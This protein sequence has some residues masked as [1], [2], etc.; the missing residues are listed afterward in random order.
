MADKNGYL[1]I[2]TR[3]GL[4]RFDP[5]SEIFERYIPDSTVVQGPNNFGHICQN[6]KGEIFF[7]QSGQLRKII[8]WDRRKFANQLS[9]SILFEH[10]LIDKKDNIWL[11]SL[12][13][14]LQLTPN[15]QENTYNIPQGALNFSNTFFTDQKQQ[16]WLGNKEGLSKYDPIL[17][18]FVLQKQL[19]RPHTQNSSQHAV[20]QIIED[21][22]GTYWVGTR[23]GL[24]RLIPSLDGSYW[25][26]LFYEHNAN[27][28]ESLADNNIICIYEDNAGLIWIGTSTAFHFFDPLQDQ[29][30]RINSQSKNS[31]TLTDN[32]TLGLCE[33]NQGQ[34][35]VGLYDGGLDKISF[36]GQFPQ[37]STEQNWST[38]IQMQSNF[39]I[40]SPSP[41][42]LISNRILQVKSDK[43]NQIWIGTKIGLQLYDQEKD[44]VLLFPRPDKEQPH[45]IYALHIDKQQDSILWIGGPNGL[46]AFDTYHQEYIPNQQF[47]ADLLAMD[48]DQAG[49]FWIGSVEGIYCINKKGQTLASFQH[50]P[51]DSTS[52]SHNVI[53]DIHIDKTQNIW[54]G[55]LG[56]GL[57][58]LEPKSKKITRYTTAKGLSSDIIFGIL[59]DEHGYI[60]ASTNDGISKL[61]TKNDKISCFYKSE[62][63]NYAD[64]TQLSFLKSSQGEFLFGT[65]KGLNVFHPDSLRHNSFVPPVYLTAV[66]INYK[67]ASPQVSEILGTSAPFLQ[68]LTL[69]P[70]EKH[71]SFEFA[72]LNF[73]NAS[74][75]QYKFRLKGYDEKWVY[76][77]GKERYATYTNLPSGNYTFQ[78]RASN[79]NNIW[80]EE[81]LDIA[82]EVLPPF[83]KTWWFSGL[84]ILLGIGAIGS[85]IYWY[86]RRKYLQQIQALELQQ[87]VQAERERISR[88][89]H[90]NVGAQ[91]TNIA[92]NLDIVGYQIPKKDNEYIQNRIDKVS[93]N[94]RHTIQLLRDTIWAINKNSFTLEE[95]A[96]KVR[97]YLQKYLEDCSLKWEVN[98]VGDSNHRLSPTQVL[99]IFRIIQ[100]AAQNTL[101][102]AQAQQFNIQ[103]LS[104][105]KLIIIIKDDGIGMQNLGSEIPEGHYG[106][107]NMAHR[108]KEIGAEFSIH[109][110]KGVCIR[111]EL[112]IN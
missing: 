10:L 23:R 75:N 108:A 38:K 5:K 19:L 101:K 54:I 95:F 46:S 62:G 96:Q 24:W 98:I 29:V 53:L 13:Q 107:H 92:S 77:T 52:I 71:I 1:W 68:Q 20:T 97:S 106:L 32:S 81:G 11:A 83:Y 112:N 34:L 65:V 37:F 93:D 56:G 50:N 58:R 73:R 63:L 76:R 4:N 55:T 87:K 64:F 59:E 18:S 47:T 42:R 12:T 104:Q 66:H 99:N 91:L 70:A 41:K 80:N 61:D 49:N 51:K 82:I 21:K 89:L 74:Q 8:D 79:N 103:L 2:S 9:N 88:D 3:N 6:S 111:L 26:H 28:P 35:W 14:G 33:D 44:Q 85:L 57:N 22:K 39:N 105:K 78:V 7:M 43:Y 16:I 69:T 30:K 100:E 48:E 102:Y 15:N 36:K 72:A 45:I 25:Q 84:M 40:N 110:S 109:N 60:W 17:D 67:K 27:N 31:F 90:D 94:T 86:N